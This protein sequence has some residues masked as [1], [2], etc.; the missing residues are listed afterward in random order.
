MPPN[1]K[2]IFRAVVASAVEFHARRLW[3][4]FAK[5]VCFAITMP[6]EELPVIASILGADGG[7]LGLVVYRGERALQ[8]WVSVAIRDAVDEAMERLDTIHFAMTP[9]REIPRE[10]RRVL[11]ETGYS[12]LIAPLFLVKQPGQQLRELRRREAETMLYAIRAILA[13]DDAGTLVV[14]PP[15][16]DR[17]AQV[18]ALHA[19]G[20][21]RKPE[22][23]VAVEALEAG[24]DEP[25]E[26]IAAPEAVRS[27]AI[28][29]EIA[30]DDAAE[31]DRPPEP[32]DLE[33]W[34]RAEDALVRRFV[35]DA[36]GDN[37]ITRKA[38]RTFFGE[39][40][41]ADALME[42]PGVRAA[43]FEW[44]WTEYRAKKGLRTLAERYLDGELSEAERQ[45]LRGRVESRPS[46]Y[47]VESI[48]GETTALADLVH[49]GTVTV[50]ATGVA[51]LSAPDVVVAGRV[52]PAGDFQVLD[53]WSPPLAPGIAERAFAFLEQQGL[54]LTAEG[55]ATRGHLIGRLW[56]WI[57]RKRELSI[58]LQNNDG[59]PL[60]I[61]CASFT[62]ANPA[63]LESALAAR[64]DMAAPAHSEVDWLWVQRDRDGLETYLAELE[65][66][67]DRLVVHVNS[68][69]RFARVREWLEQIPGVAF[70]ASEQREIDLAKAGARGRWT[71]TGERPPAVGE[72]LKQ[73]LRAQYMAWIDQ[74]IPALGG[75]TPR[76]L[77]NTEVGQREVRRIIRNLP[78]V[79]DT[80]EASREA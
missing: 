6:T 57:A 51:E 73:K 61:H 3:T 58:N 27:L 31:L 7:E 70:E 2:T 14:L 33:G 26:P 24:E 56:D 60:E 44:L 63:A 46:F 10:V 9:M 18:L 30:G 69:R 62:V 42:R 23:R 45:L 4:R 50:W 78:R 16:L 39:D 72:L 80:K 13:A 22:V 5:E 12:K 1:A 35:R 25:V 37:A 21:P 76:E 40:A 19:S 75:K 34:L 15:P 53:P 11:R 43:M 36:E 64:D 49:G 32:D 65:L 74:P 79:A 54:A 52:R 68:A 41:D 20:D 48:D 8:D 67:G 47:R 28:I 38:L 77:S 59:D 55:I 17:R 71:S 29:E 66:A